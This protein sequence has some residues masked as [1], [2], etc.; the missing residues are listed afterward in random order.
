[1]RAMRAFQ[2]C[3]TQISATRGIGSVGL[4]IIHK[5][6]KYHSVIILNDIES[7]GI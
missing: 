2:H 5:R 7:R 3:A 6:N 1:M 4:V